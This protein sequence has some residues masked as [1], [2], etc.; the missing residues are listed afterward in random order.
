MR[1]AAEL[2][3]EAEALVTEREQGDTQFDE[4]SGEGD[5]ISVERERDLMLSATARQAVEEIDAALDAHGR[6]HV[7][8]LHARPAGASR[9]RGSRPSR[10]PR[11][12]STASSVSNAAASTGAFRRV[13]RIAPLIVVAVVV[14]RPAHEVVD[15]RDALRRAARDHRSHG[16]VPRRPQLG[17]AFSTFTNATSCW[18]CSRSASRSGSCARCA[19]PPTAWTV[20][21][22]SL[23]L[24]GALGNLCDRIFRSPGVLEG[25][26]VDFVKVGCVPVVQRG[27]LRDHGRRDRARSC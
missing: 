4:E 19:G 2:Q 7:R 20:V 27:R 17:G 22:L 6:R 12:A 10:G 16:R 15:R 18:R 23:V 14:A 25:H 24:G 11:P 8:A 5:T 9:W 13:R 26:V 21:A 1:Q 3:A